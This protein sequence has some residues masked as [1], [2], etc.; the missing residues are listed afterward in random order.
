[1][2]LAKGQVKDPFSLFGVH[3]FYHSTFITD[4]ADMADDDVTYVV[5]I[6]ERK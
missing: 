3:M 1:M 4:E 2:L 5:K 6:E